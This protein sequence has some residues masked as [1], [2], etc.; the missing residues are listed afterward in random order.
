[1]KYFLGSRIHFID[2]D[3]L[4]RPIT[5][6]CFPVS[7]FV[8]LYQLSAIFAYFIIFPRNAIQN[9][10][11][12]RKRT[13]SDDIE[14]VLYGDNFTVRIRGRVRAGGNGRGHLQSG[15]RCRFFLPVGSPSN[16]SVYPSRASDI[17]LAVET[18]PSLSR[19]FNEVLSP[20]STNFGGCSQ[21]EAT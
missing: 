17:V 9:I 7:P 21:T 10:I 4:F 18:G 11:P 6:L 12:R 8:S 13:S 14:A 20:L 19:R 15:T 2:A 1:M 5:F 16:Q 3:I